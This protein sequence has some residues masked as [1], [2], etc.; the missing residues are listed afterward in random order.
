MNTWPRPCDGA[1]RIPV[2]VCFDGERY[3]VSVAVLRTHD[4]DQV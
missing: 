3:F 4:V 1:H 2:R